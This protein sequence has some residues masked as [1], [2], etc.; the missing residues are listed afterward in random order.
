MIGKGRIYESVLKIGRLMALLT[1]VFM[2]MVAEGAASSVVNTK[3]PTISNRTRNVISASTHITALQDNLTDCLGND[4]DLT[5]GPHILHNNMWGAPNEQLQQGVYYY[6]DGRFGWEW[7]RPYPQLS[8]CGEYICPTYPEV[9]IGS[10]SVAY[11]NINNWTSRVEY[12][13]NKKPSGDYNLA[14][15]LYW[16]DPIDQYTKKFNVMIW[17]VGRHDDISIG[18]VSDGTNEY[19]VY[20][21]APNGWQ[22]WPWY[23]FVLKDQGTKSNTTNMK[24]TVNIKALV[25]QLPGI[26]GDWL[27]NN[28]EFGSEVW[29]ESGRIEISNYSV[30]VNGKKYE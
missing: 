18:T 11:K 5:I 19:D 13:W 16:Y 20:Y 7:N 21:R 23:A 17:L 8:D 6:S 22:Y 26:N 29:D 27:I 28:V 15:D 9:I 1:F 2:I 10:S 25:D 14:Y 24:N 3:N 12:T 4:C 30:S